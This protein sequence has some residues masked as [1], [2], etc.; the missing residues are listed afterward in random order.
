MN[1]TKFL[2]EVCL[3]TIIDSKRKEERE[4]KKRG[5][6]MACDYYINITHHRLE[7]KSHAVAEKPFFSS[8]FCT[9][10]VQNL[11]AE[12]CYTLLVML[13]G[14]KGGGAYTGFYFP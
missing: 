8:A 10:F 11:C 3:S 4:V 2:Q 12:Y 5:A 7:G 13:Y 6:K 9:K 14:Q 1:K